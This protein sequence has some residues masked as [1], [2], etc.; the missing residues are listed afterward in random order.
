MSLSA[1]GLALSPG[2]VAGLVTLPVAG[3]WLDAEARHTVVATALFAGHWE[4]R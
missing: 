3:R 4:W 1:A 2:F